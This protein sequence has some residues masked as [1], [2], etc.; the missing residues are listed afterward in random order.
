MSAKVVLIEPVDDDVIGEFEPVVDAELP[1]LTPEVA[2]LAC[3]TMRDGCEVFG[4]V[5]L[6]GGIFV[7]GWDRVPWSKRTFPWRETQREYVKRKGG[8]WR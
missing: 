5:E 3:Y 2:A 8:D 6:A 4:V 7:T 1:G